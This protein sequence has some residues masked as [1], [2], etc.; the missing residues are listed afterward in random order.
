[1][2]VHSHGG[3]LLLHKV[4]GRADDLL[5]ELLT[6]PGGES[7]VSLRLEEVPAQSYRGGVDVGR[8]QT[9]VLVSPAQL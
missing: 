2:D 9:V 1:M 5:T 7:Q 8:H 3:R 4:L 6:P